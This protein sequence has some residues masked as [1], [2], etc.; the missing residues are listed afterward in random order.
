MESLTNTVSAPLALP[1]IPLLEQIR[2]R[3]ELLLNPRNLID[4][5]H[6]KRKVS[7]TLSDQKRKIVKVN[8]S[9][10][11][12]GEQSIS[13]ASPGKS[14]EPRRSPRLTPRGNSNDEADEESLPSH[15]NC[16]IDLNQPKTEHSTAFATEKRKS[17]RL[18]SA[19]GDASLVKNPKPVSKPAMIAIDTSRTIGYPQ[20]LIEKIC[21]LYVKSPTGEFP[22]DVSKDI[23]EE[24]TQQLIKSAIETKMTLLTP[25][26]GSVFDDGSPRIDYYIDSKPSTVVHEVN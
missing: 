21:D 4:Q 5:N 22:D 23:Q 10:G 9:M 17:P 15:A 14:P 18:A 12:D 3:I 11:S 6:H 20:R 19:N 8:P 24:L 26:Q 7:P 16:I 2:H 13:K 25:S 1:T